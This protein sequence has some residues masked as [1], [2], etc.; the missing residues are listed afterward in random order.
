[1]DTLITATILGLATSVSAQFGSGGYGGFSSGS[2]YGSGSGSDSNPFSS[3]SGSGSGDNDG[4]GGFSIASEFAGFD[5]QKAQTY[6]LAHGVMASLA[7]VFFFPAGA[8]SIRIIPSR[9]AIWIHAA[10]QL[11]AYVLYIAAFALG[12]WLVQE[13]KFSS[14]NLLSNNAVN[15]H[16]IIGIVV[17]VFL[18]FQPILGVMHHIMFKKYQRRQVWSYAHLWLGRILITLGIINGGLGLRLA[19]NTKSGEIA[20]GVV[21]GIIWLIWMAAAVYGELKRA[22][23]QRQIQ[24]V[25]P[26]RKERAY[27]SEEEAIAG[28][29]STGAY[30]PA[31]AP[32]MDPLAY[33]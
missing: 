20:Y 12:V 26:R 14:F 30:A 6:R 17:F 7:F 11:L 4:N 16:P 23:A 21:A 29:D 3:S 2:G 8:I 9:A 19:D 33:R 13:V 15:Y 31:H 10:F 25:A 18:F 28:V 1:M 22:R 5:L 27:S 32:P 24:E